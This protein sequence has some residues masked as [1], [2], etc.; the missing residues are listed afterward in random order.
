MTRFSIQRIQQARDHISPVFMGSPQYECEPLSELLGCRL[1]LKVETIN[2]IRCFKGRGTELAVAKLIA[3]GHS[4][5]VCASAGNLGQALAY[6]GRARSLPTTVVASAAA[7]AIKLDRIRGLGAEVKLVDG[8]IEVARATASEIARTESSALIED[9]ENLQTCEGAATIGVELAEQSEP[10]DTIL[11]AL[12]GG[13]MATGVGYAMKELSPK[14]KVVCVQ[15]AGAPAMTLSWR[16]KDVIRTDSIDTIA[17]G[18]A[19]RCPIPEVL[20]DLLEVAD[21]A[22]LVE[23]VSIKRGMRAIHEHGGLITE[24]SAALGVAALLEN[25]E[26]FAGQRVASIIC[27]SNVDLAQF[28]QWIDSIE[29]ETR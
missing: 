1:T 28:Q 27:G 25:R 29:D 3:D 4:S 9:S 6:S 16:A 26:R 17:D 2:P 20:A 24:P 14:T 13:A 12:G 18:V 21:D 19:G 10:F 11:I 7:S 8:D 23:E 15:P 5:A 22:L